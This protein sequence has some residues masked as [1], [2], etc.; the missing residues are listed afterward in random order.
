MQGSSMLVFCTT[1]VGT[2]SGGKEFRRLN[3]R[4]FI[5]TSI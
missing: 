5:E 4:K 2:T 1:D 3:V